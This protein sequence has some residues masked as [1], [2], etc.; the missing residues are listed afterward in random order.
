MQFGRVGFDIFGVFFLCL[1]CR[2]WWTNPSRLLRC[3]PPYPSVRDFRGACRGMQP[4]CCKK[5]A[6]GPTFIIHTRAPPRTRC[7]RGATLRGRRV[8]AA[9]VRFSLHPRLPRRMHRAAAWALPAPAV[10]IL[11]HARDLARV[12][13]LRVARSFFLKKDTRRRTL[14]RPLPSEHPPTQ[15]LGPPR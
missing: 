4:H 7:H 6:E 15:L 1:R 8:A 14:G 2:R 13:S 3:Y 9:M 12:T 5:T 11:I 10:R